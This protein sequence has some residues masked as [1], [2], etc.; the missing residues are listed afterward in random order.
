MKRSDFPLLEEVVF[1]D[2]GGGTLKPKQVVQAIS[3]YYLKN[4]INTHS[5][6]SP[7]GQKVLREVEETRSLAATLINASQDEVIFTSGTTHS[8]NLV[9]QMFASFLKPGDEILLSIYNHTSNVIVWFEVAKKT[10]AKVV[11]SEKL[12][13]RINAQTKVVAFAQTNNTIRK[14]INIKRLYKEIKKVGAVLVNDAA[15]A[16]VHEEVSL[17]NSDVIVFSG[18]KLY[19]PTGTGILAIRKELLS[20][21]KPATFGGGAAAF[22]TK[23]PNGYQFKEHRF[24]PGT[25]NVAGII[26]LGAAIKYFN[27]IDLT[28]EAIVAE[29]AYDQLMSLPNMKMFSARGDTT[30]IFN[31][32]NVNPHDVVSFCG[33]EGIIIKAGAH[34]ANLI[35]EVTLCQY[36]IRVSIAA[37]N[38]TEDIDKLIKILKNEKD[39]LNII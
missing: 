18:T 34:C 33:D 3:D 5:P 24:E 21:L 6:D 23:E 38:T 35:E 15:Q 31:L 20:L 2:S 19:G 16:V 28:K 12:F 14:H 4:P 1:L 10:G 7:L 27:E 32:K 25:L 37:Y 39:F 29:H 9:S 8:L 30:L 11:F 22:L 36:T 17:H 26:G 13:D